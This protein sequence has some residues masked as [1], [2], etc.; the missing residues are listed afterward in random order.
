MLQIIF[1]KEK[2]FSNLVS[3]F[4][5]YHYQSTIILVDFNTVV[6]PK[7]DRK[8]LLGSVSSGGN[9]LTKPLH[10]LTSILELRD[11]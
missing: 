6:D 8:K 5:G 10:D 4:Q 11:I 9:H 7:L 2:F 3:T 1:L